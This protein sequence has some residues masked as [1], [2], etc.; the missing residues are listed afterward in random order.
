MLN[1]RLGFVFSLVLFFVSIGFQGIAQDTDTEEEEEIPADSVKPAKKPAPR[2]YYVERQH[3]MDSLKGAIKSRQDSL[4]RSTK[5]NFFVDTRNIFS[6]QLTS[7]LI[8]NFEFSYENY[9]T[10]RMTL[11]GTLGY[12]PGNPDSYG[13]SVNVLQKSGYDDIMAFSFSRSYYGAF[14]GKFLLKRFLYVGGEAFVR[15]S[16]FD[17]G[18]ITWEDTPTN[19]SGG[20]TVRGNTLDYVDSLSAQVTSA[21]LKVLFGYRPTIR[22]SSSTGLVFDFYAGF[23]LRYK[24]AS[25][26]HYT[27]YYSVREEFSP[28]NPIRYYKVNTNAD[29]RVS[30]VLPAI[31]FGIKVG[32]RF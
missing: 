29:E 19:T 23:S 22:L 25:L 1:L 7:L 3:R 4:K 28:G 24:S 30:K 9:V 27:T 31:Q 17:N 2:T 5:K 16:Y 15:H 20:T 32:L 21:G 6:V 11:G 26:H 10:P 14:S 8:K 13:K 12:K 18:R